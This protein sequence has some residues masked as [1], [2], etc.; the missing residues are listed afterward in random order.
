ME[1]VLPDNIPETV[2]HVMY[3]QKYNEARQRLVNELK[4]KKM[5]GSGTKTLLNKFKGEFSSLI[6]FF[7]KYRPFKKDIRIYLFFIYNYE[8]AGIFRFFE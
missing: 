5:S 1:I 3:C 7:E 4:A 2:E 8:I 6:F